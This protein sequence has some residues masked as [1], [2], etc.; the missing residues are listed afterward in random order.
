M[1][2]APYNLSYQVALLPGEVREVLSIP[3]PASPAVARKP[4]EGECPICFSE[5]REGSEG[6]EGGPIV[7]CRAACGQNFHAAC[8]DH[9]GWTQM[10]QQLDD[11]TCPFCRSVWVCEDDDAGR[12]EEAGGGT[13]GGPRSCHTHSL[14]L[15]LFFLI[16]FLFF[17]LLRR[18][19]DC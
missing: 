7:W 16:T 11:V 9:W 13:R 18:V 12:R 1:L 15:S 2:H 4:V 10:D 6:G 8:F 19:R 3:P 14:S 5:L 17:L